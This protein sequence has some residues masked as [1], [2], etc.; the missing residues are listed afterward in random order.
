MVAQFPVAAQVLPGQDSS[1]AAPASASAA[2]GATATPSQLRVTRLVLPGTSAV[3]E[4]EGV[5]L[6]VP[7]GAVDRPTEISITRLAVTA[8]LD[9]GMSNVTDGSAGWR[10]LPHGMRF[11]GPV[12]ITMAF[13]PSIADSP[14]ALSNLFTYF[15]DD[16]KVFKT[17]E[18]ANKALRTL[19]T[20]P[21]T[22]RKK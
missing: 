5:R 8:Q 13:D 12:R 21:P 7:A 11:R 16:A 9:E 18:M 2:A 20:K 6:E 4:L 17:S 10:F 15:H 14:S 22:K 3:L 1:P 19:I